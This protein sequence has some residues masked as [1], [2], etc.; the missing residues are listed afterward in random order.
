MRGS[1]ESD[2][3]RTYGSAVLLLG[4][5]PL[6]PAVAFTPPVPTSGPAA[7]RRQLGRRGQ[8]PVQGPPALRTT[9]SLHFHRNCGRR[10]F[11]GATWLPPGRLYAQTL[12]ASLLAPQNPRN[13]ARSNFCGS[14]PSAA[15]ITLC[16]K[17]Y[18]R[19]M[20]RRASLRLPAERTCFDP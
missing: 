4:D 6:S 18:N 7:S 5:E 10:Y 16:H 14:I 8:L 17:R 12:A 9:R 15:S 19:P 1:S 20:A 2:P 3:C 11:C 13:I